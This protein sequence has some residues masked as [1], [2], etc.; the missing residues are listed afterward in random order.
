M[1]CRVCENPD[2]AVHRFL[3]SL[4]EGDFDYYMCLIEE[5]DGMKRKGGKEMGRNEDSDWRRK[6]ELEKLKWLREA[7][8]EKGRMRLEAEE[9]RRVLKREAEEDKAKAVALS[10]E[11]Q[12][13]LV[14]ELQESLKRER[15][16]V[17]SIDM[18]CDSVRR[19]EASGRR[20]KSN[21]EKGEEGEDKVYRMLQAR[22]PFAMLDRTSLHGG[23]MGD[24]AITLPGTGL[25]V[26]IE[27]KNHRA[28]VQVPGEQI[29]RFYTDL[30]N[31]R[32]SGGLLV[33]LN[34]PVSEN[35]E[36]FSIH[37]PPSCDK[38]AMFVHNLMAE[39]D[40]GLVLQVCLLNLQYA[41]ETSGKRREDSYFE[42]R[43]RTSIDR[44]NQTLEIHKK[45]CR[46]VS[47]LQK[48]C[49]SSKRLLQELIDEIRV[50]LDKAPTP[51]VFSQA[52][53]N[54][55]REGLKLS[56]IDMDGKKININKVEKD[57]FNG[58]HP[59]IAKKSDDAIEKHIKN[60]SC[61]LP[62]EDYIPDTGQKKNKEDNVVLV[63]LD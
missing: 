55:K 46:D 20:F 39:E 22:F 11:G 58:S 23:H 5:L 12:E 62:P 43:L 44:I 35:R 60:N 42:T 61:S 48:N 41:M 21:Y 40:P 47:S 10:L 8:V 57:E 53:G 16:R 9:E 37:S 15:E 50:S 25:T 33:S 29:G 18:I 45:M 36:S 49:L 28:G 7:E 51:D 19:I 38:P 32:F 14:Q 1:P 2:K 24:A 17:S 3:E 4:D 26:M 27:V 13:K 30:A 52:F 6:L 31:E 63:Q 34:G 54:R 56:D 59:K